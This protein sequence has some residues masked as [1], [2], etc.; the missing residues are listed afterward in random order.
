M[1]P[2]GTGMCVHTAHQPAVFV[3][4][5]V[6]GNIAPRYFPVVVDAEA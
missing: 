4:S 2:A 1:I 3:E 5:R 6:A